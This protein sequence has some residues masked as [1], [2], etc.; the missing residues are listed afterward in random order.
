[1]NS[2]NLV[3]NQPTE[4]HV[5]FEPCSPDIWGVYPKIMACKND[6]NQRFLLYFIMVM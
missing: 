5:W 4:G 1:M 6:L 3:L 2:E